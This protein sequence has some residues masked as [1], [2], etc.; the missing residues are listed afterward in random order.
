MCACSHGGQRSIS[1]SF[2]LVFESGSLREPGSHQFYQ[3][4]F[5]SSCWWYRCAPLCLDFTC[6]LGN[7]T[8]LLLLAKQTLYLLSHLSSPHLFFCLCFW[9]GDILLYVFFFFLEED[10]SK[11][12]RPTRARARCFL[13]PS[14]VWATPCAS[15]VDGLYTWMQSGR[16]VAASCKLFITVTPVLR[17]V[18]TACVNV[19]LHFCNLKFL[20]T[21]VWPKWG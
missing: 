3:T 17:R 18:S 19:L 13:H 14:G 12:H 11:G 9:G 6:T 4:V 10:P 2:T 16:H 8:Q 7:W 20:F 5:T 15:Q 1:A 21:V